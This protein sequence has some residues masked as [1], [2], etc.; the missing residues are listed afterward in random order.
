MYIQKIKP[1]EK[2]RKSVALLGRGK[3]QTVRC[4]QQGEVK[5]QALSR[6]WCAPAIIVIPGCIVLIDTGLDATKEEKP[7]QIENNQQQHQPGHPRTLRDIQPAGVPHTAAALG[8]SVPYTIVPVTFRYDIKI[9]LM[10]W[11]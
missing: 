10:V 1:R 9:H 8:S 3:Q 6:I 11:H 4:V 2:Q 7:Q 5:C